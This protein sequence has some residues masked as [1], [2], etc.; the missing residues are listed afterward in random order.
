VQSGVR[1]RPRGCPDHRLPRRPPFRQLSEVRGGAAVPKAFL[2]E[3]F[4]SREKRIIIEVS[5]KK[6]SIH[7]RSKVDFHYRAGIRWVE[8]TN[9]TVSSAMAVIAICQALALSVGSSHPERVWSSE[10]S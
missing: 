4:V 6:S 2:P 7:D 10:E 9:E 1:R 3:L 5:G 8:V